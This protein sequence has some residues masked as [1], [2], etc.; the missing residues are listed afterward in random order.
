[1]VEHAQEGQEE[2]DQINNSG[3]ASQVQWKEM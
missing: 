1:M 2:T 3:M